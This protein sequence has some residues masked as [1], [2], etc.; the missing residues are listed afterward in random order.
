MKR[1]ATCFVEKVGFEPRTLGTEAERYDHCAT[2]PV[3]ARDTSIPRLSAD[4][5]RSSSDTVLQFCPSESALI[6]HQGQ[7]SHQDSRPASRQDLHPA[8]VLTHVSSPAVSNL[9]LNVC[10]VLILTVS[11]LRLIPSAWMTMTVMSF[12]ISSSNSN[13]RVWCPRSL[14]RH[15]HPAILFC[16]F[17]LGSTSCCVGTRLQCTYPLQRRRCCRT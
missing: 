8:S 10:S 14:A 3:L 4:S 2:R 15:L 9:N 7:D 17:R 5:G 16:I 13:L 1:H 12:C 11:S 6:A